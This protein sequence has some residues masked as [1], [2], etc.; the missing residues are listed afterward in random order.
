MNEKKPFDDGNEFVKN[1]LGVPSGE[2]IKHLPFPLR[3][4]KYCIIGFIGFSFI[5]LIFAYMIH[6]FN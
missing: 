2:K 1:H 4:I 3:I 5:M 6:F